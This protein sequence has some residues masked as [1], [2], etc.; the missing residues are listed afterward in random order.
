MPHK[1]PLREDVRAVTRQDECPSSIYSSPYPS[2]NEGELGEL[3]FY[4]WNYRINQPDGEDGPY[5]IISQLFV[6]QKVLN[7][8]FTNA[9]ATDT[10]FLIARNLNITATGNRY[11]QRSNIR[12]FPRPT[13]NGLNHFRKRMVETSKMV[14]R[15]KTRSNTLRTFRM[16]VTYESH[17][18]LQ[19]QER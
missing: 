5:I 11:T 4:R 2:V 17:R 14:F 7:E 9:T 19:C 18:T 8:P 3:G 12:Q 16:S 13:C 6:S 10:V 15:M 1:Q